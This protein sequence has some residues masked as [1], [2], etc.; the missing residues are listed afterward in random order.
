MSIIHVN[1][2]AIEFANRDNTCRCPM[3]VT[4]LPSNIG[5]SFLQ[6]TSRETNKNTVC[7]QTKTL[8][9]SNFTYLNQQFE[10]EDILLPNRL[11]GADGHESHPP[12]QLVQAR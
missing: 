12:D 8:G 4:Q 11:P 9:S 5:S 1:K 10:H 2:E 6:S 7:Y 3:R